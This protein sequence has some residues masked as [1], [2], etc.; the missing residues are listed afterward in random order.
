MRNDIFKGGQDFMVRTRLKSVESQ[1]SH[2]ILILVLVI[3]V[4]TIISLV[5]HIYTLDQT[6]PKVVIN[7]GKAAG[8]V[9]LTILPP[10]E[11][12]KTAGDIHG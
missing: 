10:E 9:R 3:I 7:N 6:K 11:S 4:I 8:E 5:V 1:H 12:Q 2:S